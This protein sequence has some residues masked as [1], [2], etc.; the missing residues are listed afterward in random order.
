MTTERDA[1]DQPR[2]KPERRRRMQGALRLLVRQPCRGRGGSTKVAGHAPTI[3]Q[4]AE[5]KVAKRDDM[6]EAVA[7]PAQ[8]YMVQSKRWRDEP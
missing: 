2:G 4:P 3:P 1:R 5:S 8:V 6:E 7:V